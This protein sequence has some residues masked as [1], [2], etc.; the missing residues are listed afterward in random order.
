MNNQTKFGVIVVVVA[1]VSGFLGS[2][3]FY[4]YKTS[5]DNR[6]ITFSDRKNGPSENL[7]ENSVIEVSKI[8][9]PAV[10]SIIATKEVTTFYQDPFSF[11][12]NDNLLSPF[13]SPNTDKKS[14]TQQQKSG[15]SGFIINKDGLVVT[16]KHVVAD[17]KADYTVILSNGKEYKAEIVSKDPIDDFA[18]IKLLDIKE[19]LPTVVIGDSDDMQIGQFVVAIGNALAEFQNS[20]TFGVISAKGRNLVAGNS[21]GLSKEQLSGLFQTDTAI[22]PGNSG[23]PLVNL[24]GEVIGI[25]T[26]IASNAQNIG[27]AIPINKLKGSLKSIQ[28][29]GKIERPFLGV[30]YVSINKELSEKFDLKVTQGAWVV[31]NLES[32]SPAIVKDSPAAKAGIKSGDVITKV[33]DEDI[34]DKISLIDLVSKYPVDETIKLTILRDGKE[35]VLDVKL[36]KRPDIK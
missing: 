25:N 11:F 27:F 4:Q 17:E 28:E 26:A 5:F 8:V 22:N 32:Q 15:G 12:F 35:I 36:A 20:V 24:N 14:I 13:K 18:V 2:F 30:N 31:D 16:N 21:N 23:G 6:K 10:V 3:I 7:V 19:D 33:N 34:T 9:S 1:M 29:T